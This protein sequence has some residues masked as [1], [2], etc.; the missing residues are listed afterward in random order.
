MNPKYK[1]GGLVLSLLIILICG[2]QMSQLPLWGWWPFPLLVA[3]W[4]SI[5]LLLEKKYNTRWLML[6][7]LSGILLW[8]GFP[9]MPFT[10]LLFVAYIPLLIIEKEISERSY[11]EGVVKYAFNAFV[12]WNILSTWWVC[13]AGL[14][15]GMIANYLN[16]FFMCIP[17]WLF[18]KFNRMIN[19]TWGLQN[20]ILERVRAD[21]V[22]KYTSFIAFWLAFEYG[23]LNWEISWTWLTLG[24]AFAQYPSWVQWYEYTGVFGG[25]FWIL[26][27]NVLIFRFIEKKYYKKDKV[28]VIGIQIVM[29]L[30]IPTLISVLIGLNYKEDIKKTANIVIVQPNYEPHFE[31]F[32]VP[33]SI[34]M[35]KFLKLASSQ[36]DTATDYLVFPETSFDF[37]DRDQFLQNRNVL[38]L[39]NFVNQ[40][41]NL[42][43]ITGIDALKI[44]AAYTR[45]A[46][47]ELPPSV[48]EYDNRDGTL[49]YWEAYNAATQIAAGSDSM[50][51]YKKSKLVPGPEILPYGTLLGW[52]R[53]LFRQF[54]GTVGGL[55]GQ[56]YREAF[57]HR[58]GW[59]AVAPVICYESIYGDFCT[60][61]A[62]AG[63]KALFIV[64]NDGW[65]GD[66]PG[67]MQHLKFASLRAIELRRP[68][69]RSANTGSSCFIDSRGR[70][71]QA[72]PY[73]KDAAI[74]GTIQLNDAMTV[75]T[76]LGDLL[77]RSAFNIAIG[78]LLGML[79]R[80]TFPKYF[81]KKSS[82]NLE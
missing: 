50:P 47:A 81:V 73:A 70:I 7:T 23:H 61:Y 45:T 29:W 13:N 48:R 72:T 76:Y 33:E 6:S 36:L 71:T 65:W 8:L 1:K 14:I 66:T 68:V 11:T 42:H 58:N 56:P 49:T 77:G 69:I 46:P 80:L 35:Q 52:L 15:A 57:W 28:K 79:I 82:Q 27:L 43:L 16:A 31:K 24:N 5:V 25:S 4:A 59:T 17:F 30:L 10:P 60:G 55:G 22:L 3:I 20:G 26:L 75:Y 32:D 2:F 44:Y 63:A 54:G 19:P 62:K 12:I 34:Q 39:K 37:R 41:P 64:T 21:E 74:K 78:L 9:N 53:P 40:Y 38:D 67:Y 18:H 51:F